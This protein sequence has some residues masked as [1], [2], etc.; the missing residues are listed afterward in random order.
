MLNYKKF[1]YKL[2]STQGTNYDKPCNAS[3]LVLKDGTYSMTFNHILS[4]TYIQDA[5]APIKLRIF[6][7]DVDKDRAG[8][9]T[10]YDTKPGTWI[11][12][13]ANAA[14]S[15]NTASVA[16]DSDGI[17]TITPSEPLGFLEGS[18]TFTV[19]DT[20]LSDGESFKVQCTINFKRVFAKET[21]TMYYK[22]GAGTYTQASVI[23]TEMSDYPYFQ[24]LADQNFTIS[25]TKKEW[26]TTMTYYVVR[27]GLEIPYTENGASK[28]NTTKYP[29]TTIIPVTQ[30]VLPRHMQ[31]FN[32]LYTESETSKFLFSFRVVYD[33]ECAPSHYYINKVDLYNNTTSQIVDIVVTDGDTTVINDSTD[34]EAGT[35]IKTIGNVIFHKENIPIDADGYFLDS[36]NNRVKYFLDLA[37]NSSYRVY[38]LLQSTGQVKETIGTTNTNLII[39]ANDILNKIHWPGELITL[40]SDNNATLSG[41]VLPSD[42][43]LEWYFDLGNTLKSSAV[44][45]TNSGYAHGSVGAIICEDGVRN[46]VSSKYDFTKK[47]STSASYETYSCMK[48]YSGKTIVLGNTYI[49]ENYDDKG[50]GSNIFPNDIIGDVPYCKYAYDSG[51]LKVDTAGNPVDRWGSSLM[52]A[53]GKYRYNTFFMKFYLEAETTT[54][55]DIVSGN[56]LFRVQVDTV[57]HTLTASIQ[58]TITQ[59]YTTSVTINTGTWYTLILIFQDKKLKGIS[60]LSRETRSTTNTLISKVL[61]SGDQLDCSN[62]I[63]SELTHLTFTNYTDTDYI[64]F[65][66]SNSS[67]AQVYLCRIGLLQKDL[68]TNIESLTSVTLSEFLPSNIL[69]LLLYGDTLQPSVHIVNNSTGDSQYITE[70][71]ETKSTQVSFYLP[72][73]TY[74]SDGNT[75][76]QNPL[77]PGEY[78]AYLECGGTIYKTQKWTIK[79]IKPDDTTINFEC[80]FKNDYTNAVTTFLDRFYI[81]QEKRAGDLSGGEN[82][83]NVYL[84]KGEGCVVFENHG[85]YYGEEEDQLLPCNQKAPVTDYYIG[86]PAEILKYDLNDDNTICYYDSTHVPDPYK[87]RVKRVGS[88]VQ[89]KDYY[90]YGE[91]KLRMKIPKDFTGAAICWWMFHYQEHYTNDDNRFLDFYTGGLDGSNKAVANSLLGGYDIVG[92]YDYAKSYLP[93]NYLHDFSM[94][95]GKPYIKVNNEIDMEMGSEVCS[96]Y[97][98]TAP[99]LSGLQFHVSAIDKKTVYFCTTEGSNYGLWVVDYDSSTTQ[100]ALTAKFNALKKEYDESGTIDRY[101]SENIVIA[102]NQLAWIHVSS[103]SSLEEKTIEGP[104]QQFA[105]HSTWGI[106]WNNWF[107]EGDNS[108]AILSKSTF[109]S[110]VDV[111]N[112]TES[113]GTNGWATLNVGASMTLRTPLGIWDTTNEDINKRFTPYRYDDDKYHDYR[114][115]WHRDYTAL[116]IDDELVK[117]NRMNVP[118]IPMAALIGVWFPTFNSYDVKNSWKGHFGGWGGLDAKWDVRHLKVSYI[119]FK[120]YSEEEEPRDKLLYHSESFPA[121]GLRKIEGSY[122]EDNMV[123]LTVTPTPSYATVYINNIKG[124]SVKVPKGEAA[125]VS[126]LADGYS[127]YTESF[128]VSKDTSKNITLEE[129]GSYSN[130]T[131]MAQDMSRISTNLDAL[132][133]KYGEDNLVMWSLVTDQHV[134]INDPGKT[135]TYQEERES[136][137]KT[138]MANLRTLGEKYKFSVF[139][140]GGDITGYIGEFGDT[141]DEVPYPLTSEGLLQATDTLTQE[142][143]NNLNTTKLTTYYTPEYNAALSAFTSNPTIPVLTA[144]GNHDRL[145]NSGTY[146]TY[147]PLSFIKEQTITPF[148]SMITSVFTE[149]EEANSNYLYYDDTTKKVRFI[150]LDSYYEAWREHWK[151][152][153]REGLD[154]QALKKCFTQP[155]GWKY[156]ILN[157]DGYSKGTKLGAT[158]PGNYG[159][160][161]C[162]YDVDFGDIDTKDL[163]VCLNGHGH[164]NIQA[165][166]PTLNNKVFEVSTQA[167]SA[168]GSIFSSRKKSWDIAPEVPW[169]SLGTVASHAID[170][171]VYNKTNNDLYVYRWGSGSDRFFN[172]DQSNPTFKYKSVSWNFQ[173]PTITDFTNYT[174]LLSSRLDGQYFKNQVSNY[175]VAIKLYLTNTGVA[176]CTNNVQDSTVY[177]LGIPVDTSLRAY[178]IDSN[179]TLVWASAV[180]NTS[181]LE[182]TQTIILD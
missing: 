127:N 59:T 175:K 77:P 62:L 172:V 136:N 118:F 165:L 113:E 164:T 70:F 53:S 21:V 71:V 10:D 102:A 119:S 64:A 80:D 28:T 163:I 9:D 82:G 117:I 158:I 36:D 143:I 132:I 173:S 27:P 66:T 7:L 48:F 151:G 160:T 68:S 2:F 106:R 39:G 138:W 170:I 78:T 11:T 18:L 49:K 123:T 41:N 32:N 85:D 94:D 153:A 129:A 90:N 155:E 103:D 181:D 61:S 15:L 140:N 139:L 96:V 156:V 6:G 120:E 174:L 176:S 142:E 147:V 81:R 111:I 121:D 135:P 67:S 38:S 112:G 14:F 63:N 98:S 40:A 101:N 57:N 107:S 180:F 34:E 42:D 30:I 46:E 37:D 22:I 8:T 31:R 73:A 178:L 79:S 131:T 87:T 29:D 54:L 167:A 84:N 133:S 88:L 65:P 105:A 128:I 116:Y 149:G 74:A 93:F 56:E 16:I 171:Y 45:T 177:T 109:N 3:T 12:T 115:E 25:L 182:E 154:L 33:Q 97:G 100:N 26:D 110:I 75:E 91:W 122:I 5:S 157:H 86:A 114:F 134:T 1:T 23:C 168:A 124:T 159:Y 69:Q 13:I 92:K 162:E 58:G 76:L 169:I 152:I 95:S 51:V 55:M 83:N 108:T 43:G 144:P 148:A 104:Y 17:I 4:S 150:V 146:K 125:T 141:A 99:S 145:G 130:I 35:S 179:D 72:L 89:S 161:D 52:P 24:A 47:S 19:T 126:I 20:A 60:L 50:L 137:T 44:N 166:M